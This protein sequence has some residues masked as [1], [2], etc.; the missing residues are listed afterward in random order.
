MIHD[1][2]ETLKDLLMKEGKLNAGEIDI[3]F[4]Q[5]TG[6]W[7]ASLSRPTVN[8][9]LYDIRENTELRT[10]SPQVQRDDTNIAK[11][12]F[13]PK[14]IDLSY[15]LTVWARNP[16]DE[17][18]LLWRILLA[19][20]KIKMIE[21]ERG[22]GLV[23]EQP[24]NMPTKVALPSDAVR[25]MPD[26]WGVME[27]QLKPSINFLVTVALDLE[28]IILAPMVLTSQIT[29]G[30]AYAKREELSAVSMTTYHI[31]GN[32]RDQE[33]PLVGARVT[34]LG[35]GDE[36]ATD[37]DGRYVFA[38]MNAGDYDIE[39]SAEGR[40]AKKYKITVPAPNYDLAL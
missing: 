2:D 14:R 18:Q 16:E 9:Y 13:P 12:V 34:L 4:D 17:H 15:L 35:R 33:G 5:P 27:N 20:S 36:V 3:A 31:G 21:P 19:L 32:V 25:N 24:Y 39:V 30:Q 29:V 11:R 7:T 26:L 28:E 1:L 23:K 8:I 38:Y 10:R 40:K 22:K 37:T 6:E